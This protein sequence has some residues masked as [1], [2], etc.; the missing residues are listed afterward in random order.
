MFA[1]RSFCTTWFGNTTAS[2]KLPVNAPWP[3]LVQPPRVARTTPCALPT[4]PSVGPA[5]GPPSAAL[6]EAA[7]TPST[8]IVAPSSSTD[9]SIMLLIPVVGSLKLSST[10]LA[11][12]AEPFP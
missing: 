4:P 11:S 1:A 12:A 8:Q 3:S 9:T 5:F 2:L 7:R 6:L 10:P